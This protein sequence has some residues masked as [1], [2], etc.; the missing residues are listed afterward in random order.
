MD[1]C[2]VGKNRWA[3]TLKGEFYFWPKIFRTVEEEELR[4]DNKE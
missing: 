4:F 1:I 2:C 3:R